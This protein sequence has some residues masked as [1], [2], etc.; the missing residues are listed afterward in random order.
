MKNTNIAFTIILLFTLSTF[1]FAQ[2]C[3]YYSMSEGMKLGYQN[4]DAKGKL[5]SSR[6]M[7]CL[8]VQNTGGAVIY[9][10][11]SDYVDAKNSNPSSSEYEMRCEDG[12]F[13]VNMQNLLDPKSMESFKGMEVS[14][15]SKDMIYPSGLSAGQTLP[16][17]S[18]TVSAGSGGMNIMNMVVTI[19][20]R[21]V[22]GSESVTVPAGTFDC[23][24]ITYDV[25]TK[26]MFKLNT[27]VVEYVNMGVG[28]VKTE[29]YDKKGKIMGTT[30]L[31]ELKK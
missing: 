2:D 11:K 14:V 20:N 26:L 24:K 28:S 25:E 5:T 19:T 9:T 8:G 4:L 21:Q 30:V 18:I 15:D 27:T 7:T 16:D 1:S 6:S 13:Y 3:S 10:I 31:S 29:T 12:K 22:V 17:A 23:Y